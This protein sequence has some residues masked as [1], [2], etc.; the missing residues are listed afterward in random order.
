MDLA[1]A[2]FDQGIAAGKRVDFHGISGMRE[3]MDIAGES[4]NSGMVTV[5]KGNMEHDRS[6]RSC[7]F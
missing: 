5:T 7:I 1:A 6:L 2:G 4:C 3:L